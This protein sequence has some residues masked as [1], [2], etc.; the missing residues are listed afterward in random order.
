MRRWFSEPV[1]VWRGTL[2]TRN[3]QSESVSLEDGW[4]GQGTSEGK[5]RKP[6]Q[7]EAA[8]LETGHLPDPDAGNAKS[9]RGNTMGAKDGQSRG[10][11]TSGRRERR[12]RK[13]KGRE[14]GRVRNREVVTFW[15]DELLHHGAIGG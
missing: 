2:D 4:V 8:A 9:T 3:R 10:E 15:R 6:W 7:R 5:G 13:G 14:G 11:W 12:R 1:W